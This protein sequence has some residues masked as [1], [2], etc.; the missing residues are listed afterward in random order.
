LWGLEIERSIPDRNEDLYWVL[1]TKA[2]EQ[3][4]WSSFFGQLQGLE[5]IN[6][7]RGV[8]LVPYAA[9]DLTLLGARDPPNPCDQKLSG[10]AGADLKAGLGSN[11]TLDATVN[12]DF[13]QVEADPA[14]VNLT[15]FE[16]VFDEKRPFF[17]EGN[18][19]LTGRAQGYLGR[20]TY[21]YTRRIGARPH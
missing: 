19:I 21:F 8:E 10:R 15:A 9:G 2:K 17:I 3:S 4:G 7:S 5:G 14:Q 18:E 16:T 13:G 6:T 12:P 11:L 1:V 20:P